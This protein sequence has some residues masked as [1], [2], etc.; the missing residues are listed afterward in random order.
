M[1]RF[2]D[3][4]AD[5]QIYG[6]AKGLKHVPGRDDASPEDIARCPWKEDWPHYIRVYGAEFLAG[7]LQIGISLNRMMEELGSDAFSSTQRHAQA[8]AGNTNPRRAYL[9]KAAVALTQEGV[10]WLQREFE[11]ALRRNGSI[12]PADLDA[13][14][15]PEVSPVSPQ[16]W[17]PREND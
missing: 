14:Y 6:R 4:P 1:A 15:W 8:Q 5:I 10:E 11:L 16:P 13:L 12:P 17:A 7:T 9:Q 3:E 2:V